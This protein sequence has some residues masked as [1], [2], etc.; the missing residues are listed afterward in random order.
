MISLRKHNFLNMLGLVRIGNRELICISWITE[1]NHA[2]AFGFDV[3]FSEEVPIHFG[4]NIGKFTFHIQILG[5]QYFP[6]ETSP[7]Y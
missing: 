2:P 1:W 4:M 3:S 6:N 7:S 5:V